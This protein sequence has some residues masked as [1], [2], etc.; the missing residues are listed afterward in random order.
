MLH[1]IIPPLFFGIPRPVVKAILPRII[2]FNV[3]TNTLKMTISIQSMMAKSIIDTES[4]QI[5]VI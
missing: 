3:Y 4:I 1:S 5:K 2:M